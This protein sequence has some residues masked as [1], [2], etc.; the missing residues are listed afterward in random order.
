MS[1]VV[2]FKDLNKDSIAV[3]GGKG[4]NLGEMFN[5]GLPVP[6]GFAVTAQTYAEFIENT[7]LKIK[8]EQLLQG[9]NIED[10]ARLQE[11]ARKIQELIIDTVMP[12]KMVEEIKES[13]ELLGALGSKNRAQDL[14]DTMEV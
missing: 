14:L 3:A 12:E 1:Y 11:L 13:Y 8:I 9:L 10:T 5:L 4:A 6:P 7:G 2:W